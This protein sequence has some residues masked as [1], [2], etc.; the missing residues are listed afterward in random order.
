MEVAPL[1]RLQ[2]SRNLEIGIKSFGQIMCP[3]EF[4]QCRRKRK[5]RNGN[6]PR[7]KTSRS[8]TAPAGG[9]PQPG[10][11]PAR[12][13]PPSQFKPDGRGPRSQR[14]RG[15]GKRERMTGGARLSSLTR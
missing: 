7:G 3:V 11:R 15:A 14:E 8:A 2:Y 4:L 13:R 6:A 9:P 1:N 12:A 10:Q 5:K